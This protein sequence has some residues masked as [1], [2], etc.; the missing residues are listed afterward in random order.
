M[1]KCL[2]CGIIFEIPKEQES[3]LVCNEC[4]KQE[5]AKNANKDRIQT[6]MLDN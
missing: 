1:Y 3:P 6:D 5:G 4:L 2:A